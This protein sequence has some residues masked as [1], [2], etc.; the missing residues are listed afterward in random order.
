M[1]N[2]IIMFI[3]T[4]QNDLPTFVPVINTINHLHIDWNAV[5][6]VVNYKDYQ[7]IFD[8]KIKI[9]D[10]N[11]YETYN[12]NN[13]L[14]I[15]HPKILIFGN[16][17][18]VI[19]RSFIY[20]ANDMSIKSILIPHGFVFKHQ[21]RKIDVIRD[22][23]K[24]FS[25]N[26]I[27]LNF[28]VIHESKFYVKF[29]KC[30]YY[31]LKYGYSMGYS[32]CSKICSIGLEYKKLLISRG[33]NETSIEVT[34]NPRFDKIKEIANSKSDLI[35]KYF[36]INDSA[37]IIVILENA[38]LEDCVWTVNQLKEWLISIFNEV[39][40]FNN[41]FAFIKVHPRQKAEDY[42]SILNELNVFNVPVI[43]NELHLY[44]ILNESDLVIGVNSTALLEAMAFKKPVISL[45]YYGSYYSDIDG[46]GFIKSGSLIYVDNKNMLWESINMAMY[47]KNTRE[48]LFKKQA[49]FIEDNVSNMYTG[50][51]SHSIVNVISDMLKQ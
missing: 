45:Y 23:K 16:D 21:R 2:K 31:T 36:N 47:D 39:K 11:Y 33:I 50:K 1:N 17:T 46:L 51:S 49:I 38:V 22:W 42:I 34:G 41:F 8:N 4:D 6:F 19:A 28:K 43:N 24:I 13:I 10:F 15:E 18:S 26:Q 14:R 12:V 25:K 35:R 44:D 30:A 48:T 27:K 32:G 5:L 9:C 29:I 37:K 7:N 40:K 3:A 20:A